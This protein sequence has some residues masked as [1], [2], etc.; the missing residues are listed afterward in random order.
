[1]LND[2]SIALWNVIIGAG[3]AVK[4]SHKIK[5]SLKGNLVNMD[6]RV[7]NGRKMF[8]ANIINEKEKD[9]VIDDTGCDIVYVMVKRD[10]KAAYY[11]NI[12]FHCGE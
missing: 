4:P 5:I 6:I 3:D 8:V 9:Y 10:K 1:M 11:D 7:K 2:K 12:P